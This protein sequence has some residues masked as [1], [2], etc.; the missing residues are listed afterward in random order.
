MGRK[1]IYIVSSS[2]CS[3]LWCVSCCRLLSTRTSFG[4]VGGGK[5]PRP[6]GWIGNIRLA[7]FWESES[8]RA[9]YRKTRS[10]V[11]YFLNAK[12][13]TVGVEMMPLIFSQQVHVT[14]VTIDQPEVTLLRAASGDW[15][16]LDPGRERRCFAC[17]LVTF[18][19]LGSKCFRAEDRNQK[20]E[21]RRGT[22]G[23]ECQAAWY[24][25]MNLTA[26][27]LSYTSRFSFEFSATTP[28]RQHQADGESGAAQP[29]RRG[30]NAPGNQSGNP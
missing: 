25:Q 22:S 2:L 5:R 7:L 15:N 17:R 23:L 6:Q 26:S 30:A 12:S 11:R 10:L 18:F 19:W 21:A 27:D 28:D 24:D 20:R 3:S 14:G 13:I 16:S 29:N 8:E 4:G 9:P 1:I